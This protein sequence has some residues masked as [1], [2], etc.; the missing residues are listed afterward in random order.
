MKDQVDSLRACG[1]AAAQIDSSLS[2]GERFAYEMD[3]RQGE[4][5]LLFVSPERLV[6]TDSIASCS[7]SM[8]A[9]LPS[10]KPTAI[11]TRQARTT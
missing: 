10:T 6:Q 7:R 8:S 5:R 9:L 3:V 2:A 11:R 1:I 4:V